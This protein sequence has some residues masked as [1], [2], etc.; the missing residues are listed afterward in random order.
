M[1]G[2]TRLARLTGLDRTG[3]EVASA[4]RPRGHV[5]QATAGKGATF[6][7]AARGALMEAAE[8]HAAERP[9]EA[10]WGTAVG[11][12]ARLGADAV[13]SPRA[14]DPD[15][16]AAWDLV[17]LAWREG[18]DLLSGRPAVVP[19][20][21]VHVPPAGAPSLGPALVRWTSNGMG[22]A[23]RRD[24]AV[25]H[26]L[27]EAVE[28]DRLARALPDGFTARETARR[29]IDRATLRRSAPRAAKLADA[30]EA[31]GF[32]AYLFDL[33][34]R[35]ARSTATSV[36]TSTPTS[37]ATRTP[38]ATPTSTATSTRST[39]PA[40]TATAILP[41]TFDPG[42]PCAAA[43]IV[44]P[45]LGAVPVA[46]GYACRLGRDG[47]LVAAL[48]EAAQS[49]ATE[50]HGAR[51]DVAFGDRRA[52]VA[53]AALCERV[54]P[55]RDAARLAD[56]RARSPRA[57]LAVAL[58][59]LRRAGARRAVAVDLEGPAGVAVVKVILPGLLLSELL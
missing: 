6:E 19:A 7:D 40:P 16:D 17:H 3:V 24:A 22:A 36:P 49:R 2:V 48:L 9:A 12:A 52:A 38:T 32:G 4:I 33:G 35:G 13:V 58:A 59:R 47:A 14:L 45:H 18:T 44:D 54:R 27:L 39:A 8:L 25:L 15:G 26:A 10:R 5:L 31:R 20:H 55:R 21:A 57:A 46:A 43:L 50:I 41:A 23:P 1:A 51:E 30:I 29:M 42:L 34:G 53:L 56:L 28:R 37:T 11:L